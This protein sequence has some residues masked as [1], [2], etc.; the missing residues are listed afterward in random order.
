MGPIPRHRQLWQLGCLG[1]WPSI[2]YIIWRIDLTSTQPEAWWRNS[3]Q[4]QM[5]RAKRSLPICLSLTRLVN[6]SE[7]AASPLST[8]TPVPHL[9]HEADVFT[10]ASTCAQI[11]VSAVHS[12]TSLNCFPLPLSFWLC[13]DTNVCS[14]KI[15]LGP[16]CRLS[17]RS[18]DPWAA[19]WVRGRG[20]QRFSV[21]T[22][23]TFTPRS[24]QFS[25][26]FTN[27]EVEPSLQ[28]FHKIAPAVNWKPCSE[29]VLT[30][31]QWLFALSPSET[32]GWLIENIPVRN[33]PSCS[34][35]L[36]LYMH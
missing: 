23:W 29:P 4:D 8:I 3:F 16:N 30:C 7:Q 36:F 21:M 32:W 6:S 11:A 18:T 15:L 20:A 24:A 17:H 25:C 33:P 13:L 10:P 1:P 5:R 28:A 35:W 22:L 2:G 19:A 26:L 12:W 34:A 27:K 9:A 31:P 14:R